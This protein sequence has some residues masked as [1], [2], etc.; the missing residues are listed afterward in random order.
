MQLDLHMQGHSIIVLDFHTFVQK[1]IVLDINDTVWAAK[2][3][4]LDKI[5]QVRLVLVV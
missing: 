1:C 3:V 4:V 5:I 2:Q